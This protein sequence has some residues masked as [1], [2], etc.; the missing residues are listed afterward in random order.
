MQEGG[1]LVVVGVGDVEVREG[2]AEEVVRVRLAGEDRLH[3]DPG[4]VVE[5]RE[6]ERRRAPVVEDDAADD[7]RA[8]VAEEP[9]VGHLDPG[10]PA[11]IAAQDGLDPLGDAPHVAFPVAPAPFEARDVENALDQRGETRAGRDREIE[12]HRGG[13]FA[14]GLSMAQE[15]VLHR[16]PHALVHHPPRGMDVGEGEVRFVASFDQGEVAGLEPHP[17]RLVIGDRRQRLAQ[18]PRE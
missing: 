12:P 5:Q 10:G 15:C 1:Q 14:R 3:V 16:L 2:G 13:A 6:D 4:F 17:E 11:R 18:A 7:V 9:G 8:A